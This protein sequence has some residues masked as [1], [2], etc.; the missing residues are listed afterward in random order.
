[1]NSKSK[2]QMAVLII[3][4]GLLSFSIFSQITGGDHQPTPQDPVA[5][6]P[7]KLQSS[8]TSTEVLQVHLLETK[9][10]ELSGVKRNIFQF[11]GKD[12]VSPERPP[13]LKIPQSQ[14]LIPIPPA[15]PNVQYLGFYFE[16]DTGL[17]LAS[18][19]NSGKVYVGKVGQILG[20]KYELL[21]I[22][23]DH[24]ILRLTEDGKVLRVPLGK[25]APNVM[26][27]AELEQ[28]QEEE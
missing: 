4:L 19:S 1:M 28:E 10:P 2:K 20:G 11:E 6:K 15:L 21:E 5:A 25:G 3:L 27:S 22:A 9:V 14:A 16:P 7:V 26:N 13:V 17:K 24:I 18:I 23:A 8:P 12:V